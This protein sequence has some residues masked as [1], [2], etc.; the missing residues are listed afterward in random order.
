MYN[1]KNKELEAAG[2]HIWGDTDP[3]ENMLGPFFMK[4]KEDGTHKSAYWTSPCH[5]NSGGALH[6]GFLM[7]FADFALFAIAKKDLT[8]AGGV[9]VGFNSEFISAGKPGALIEADGEIL[10]AAKSLIFVRGMITSDGE[11]IMSFSG[12]LKK[13]RK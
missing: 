1:E 5:A 6:G 10:R 12:V 7:S 13:L 3:Y 4:E 2:Y 11:P 8:E 9:T